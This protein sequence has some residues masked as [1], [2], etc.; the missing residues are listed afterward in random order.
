MARGRKPLVLRGTADA[1]VLANGLEHQSEAPEQWPPSTQFKPGRLFFSLP[2]KNYS[3]SE[4][5]VDE[6]SMLGLSVSAL[7]NLT[8]SSGSWVCSHSTLP[9]ILKLVITIP[10]VQFLRATIGEFRV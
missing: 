3:T 9:L 5:D 1:L 6:A 4:K 8:L 7:R 2:K 10:Y